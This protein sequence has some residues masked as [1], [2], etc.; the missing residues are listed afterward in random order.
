MDMVVL[1]EH[2]TTAGRI[3]ISLLATE[4]NNANKLTRK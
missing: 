3:K 4:I 2:L 1:D